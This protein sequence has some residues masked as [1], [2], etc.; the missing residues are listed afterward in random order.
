MINRLIT[1]GAVL[2]AGVALLAIAAPAA[3]AQEWRHQSR[4]VQK[5][6][7]DGDECATF[8]CDRD[9]DDCVQVSAWRHVYARTYRRPSPYGYR[10]FG[11]SDFGYDEHDR[12]GWRD[13]RGHE[14]RRERH[15]DR[16]ED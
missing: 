7:R 5:C 3:S 8:R 4:T 2:G 11:R 1:I 13:R 16:D 6:D 9:G 15:R 10:L 12:D 14:E